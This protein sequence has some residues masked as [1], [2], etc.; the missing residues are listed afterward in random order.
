MI[1]WTNQRRARICAGLGVISSAICLR[2]SLS[3]LST[4][5]KPPNQPPNQL[6][7]LPPTIH[8]HT[9]Y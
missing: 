8:L 3:S 9:P 7:L 6:P 2:T 4:I 1:I 5:A